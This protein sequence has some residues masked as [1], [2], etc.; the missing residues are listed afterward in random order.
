MRQSC[1]SLLGYNRMSHCRR[2]L[3]TRNHS[4]VPYRN[5]V[6]SHMMVQ[7]KTCL[8]N[9]RG[10]PAA[11]CLILCALLLK[12][13]RSPWC[14]RE[15]APATVA[16]VAVTRPMGAIDDGRLAPSTST[17]SLLDQ[18]LR[19]MHFHRLTNP[20]SRLLLMLPPDQP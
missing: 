16:S 1:R 11:E 13:E 3:T 4:R 18:S 15:D 20:K 2:Y 10:C 6:P 7:T 17:K 5:L 9:R 12:V 14:E 19:R 8:L